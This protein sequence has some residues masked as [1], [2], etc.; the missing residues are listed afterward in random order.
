MGGTLA[1]SGSAVNHWF[2]PTV[3]WVWI[4]L[5]IAVFAVR[6]P[7]GAILDAS[8]AAGSCV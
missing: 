8:G 6:S 1:P 3:H 4:T 7:C 5:W 2:G